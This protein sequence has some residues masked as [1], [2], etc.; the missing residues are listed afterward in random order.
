MEAPQVQKRNGIAGARLGNYP[1]DRS[2]ARETAP[3]RFWQGRGC[4]PRFAAATPRVVSHVRDRQRR[5]PPPSSTR[6]R[7]CRRPP[8]R[9]RCRVSPRRHRPRSSRR[10]PPPMGIS[11][12]LIRA[13]RP[14][15]I[16]VRPLRVLAGGRP[17]PDGS[18]PVRRSGWA[19]K[20]PW[21]RARTSWRGQVPEHA[22]SIARRQRGLGP[23]RLQRGPTVVSRQGDPPYS[24]NPV[25]RAQRSTSGGRHH[26]AFHLPNPRP[27]PRRVRL[28]R[29]GGSLRA[30]RTL[31]NVGA[32]PVRRAGRAR[33]PVPR[34]R[35]EESGDRAARTSTRA[36]QAVL[37][38]RAAPRSKATA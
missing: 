22:C 16:A 20:I 33:L 6:G 10:R 3:A 15:R 21:T 32:S 29:R 13:R 34:G 8:R 28:S 17:G 12:D 38:S 1:P 9:P 7:H 4:W 31:T 14:D 25:L 19:G 36:R 24:E 26:A 30:T 37:R 2:A 11:A 5:R 27:P 23:G 35:L 18:C